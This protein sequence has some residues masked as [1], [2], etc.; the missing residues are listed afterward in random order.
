MTWE[1]NTPQ[2]HKLYFAQLDAEIAN[3]TL[4]DTIV[5]K[6]WCKEMAKR[7]TMKSTLQD[8]AQ[9]GQVKGD[10]D[11]SLALNNTIA[12]SNGVNMGGDGV[13]TVE[14]GILPSTKEANGVEN[15]E[16]GMIP[17][18]MEAHGD[19][20]IEPTPICLNEEMVPIP[21]EPLS[22]LERE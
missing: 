17:S 13:E 21:C 10:V 4:Q 14:H 3:K 16:H 22:P 2:A 20:K 1:C 15:G 5:F 19:E 11:S 6:E 8:E 18:P 12:P 7:T 9:E